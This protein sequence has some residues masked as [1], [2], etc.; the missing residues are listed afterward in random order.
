MSFSILWLLLIPSVLLLGLAIFAVVR[1]RTRR[2]LVHVGLAFLLVLIGLQPGVGSVTSSAG[3][4]D[5]DVLIL[6]DTTTSMSAEDWNGDKPRIKGVSA[7]AQDIVGQFAGARYAIVTFNSSAKVQVP[8]TTDAT[9]IA[10]LLGSAFTEQYYY[11]RGSSID[12]A[13]DTALEMIKQKQEKYPERRTV[14]LYI[15]DG[16]QTTDKAPASWD[17]FR[18]YVD[19]AF[20]LG[21]GT[22]EGGKMRY[23]ATSKSY[24]YDSTTHKEAVSKLDEGNLKAIAKDLGGTYLQRTSPGGLELKVDLG[25]VSAGGKGAPVGY[26]IAWLLSLPIAGW[27]LAQLFSAVFQLRRLREERR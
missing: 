24:I 11:G 20:V 16:E 23:D 15:G 2:G 22:P 4:S 7:D 3:M 26:Q 12:I 18:T 19:G 17:R 14:I 10:S 5:V 6:L 1:R 21:Y 25:K 9:S 8:W 27:L 13:Q